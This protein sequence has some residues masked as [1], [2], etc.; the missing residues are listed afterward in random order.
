MIYSRLSFPSAKNG[1]A[2]TKAESSCLFTYGGVGASAGGQCCLLIRWSRGIPHIGKIQATGSDDIFILETRP[3]CL[4]KKYFQRSVR[5]TLGFQ[6]DPNRHLPTI[7]P[8]NSESGNSLVV[9]VQNQ[10][11]MRMTV[12]KRF[13]QFTCTAS[14]IGLGRPGPLKPGVRMSLIAMASMALR[15]LSTCLTAPLVRPIQ[16]TVDG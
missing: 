13:E 7:R 3:S 10:Y 12:E 11:H 16:V 2:R 6:L 9:A 8:D 1:V 15:T 4:L 14:P 5:Q